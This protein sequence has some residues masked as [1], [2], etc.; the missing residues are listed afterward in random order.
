MQRQ[1]VLSAKCKQLPPSKG[2]QQ[3]CPNQGSEKLVAVLGAAWQSW[4]QFNPKKRW[5][6]D[7][8]SFSRNLE[9]ALGARS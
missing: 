9:R 1:F 8:Q 7:Q 4:S 5:L 2:A 3:G 6:K